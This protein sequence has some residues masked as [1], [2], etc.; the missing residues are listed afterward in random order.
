MRVAPGLVVVRTMRAVFLLASLL[1]FAACKQDPSSE[2][3][4]E[5]RADA[6]LDELR[7]ATLDPDLI[8]WTMR[9][10]FG[11]PGM[12]SPESRLAAGNPQRWTAQYLFE[13][14]DQPYAWVRAKI[15]MLTFDGPT[16]LQ[17]WLEDEEISAPVSDAEGFN[18]VVLF[19]CDTWSPGVD[20]RP[21]T[22][23]VTVL[24]GGK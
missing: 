17:A 22:E 7:I 6:E 1:A 2:T 20:K 19:E 23:D 3:Y 14:E 9:D 5:W 15:V 13:R 8:T 18:K 12:P 11:S 21:C 4:D 16:D 24:L 10:A